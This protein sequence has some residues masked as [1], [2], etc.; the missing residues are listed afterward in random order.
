MRHDK[1]LWIYKFGEWQKC[2]NTFSLK[3]NCICV[4]KK[5][6]FGKDIGSLAMLTILHF[7]R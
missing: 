4:S 2:P 6:G 7:G 1:L 3:R 5:S